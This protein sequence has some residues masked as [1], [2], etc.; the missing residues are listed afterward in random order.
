MHSLGAFCKMEFGSCNPN[1][2]SQCFPHTSSGYVDSGTFSTLGRLSGKLLGLIII[3]FF[4]LGTLRKNVILLWDFVCLI[5]RLRGVPVAFSSI[6][7]LPGLRSNIIDGQTLEGGYIM[8]SLE[9]VQIR[10]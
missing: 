1:P 7:F 5:F 9:N 2:T 4:L 6:I 3:R 10:I 8:F